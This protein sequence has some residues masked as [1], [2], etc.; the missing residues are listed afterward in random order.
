MKKQ[1]ALS[2]LFFLIA[3]SS[4][5]ATIISNSGLITYPDTGSAFPV[6]ATSQTV[7]SPGDSIRAAE[8]IDLAAL[9]F[10]TDDN[11]GAGWDT[12]ALEWV[13]QWFSPTSTGTPDA[14]FVV[15]YLWSQIT[16]DI[17][18][19]L[20]ELTFASDA[21]TP[22]ADG[23]WFVVS[24]FEN[25]FANQRAPSIAAVRVP[26]PATLLLLLIGFVAIGLVGRKKAVFSSKSAMIA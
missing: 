16:A 24:S 19:G 4:V 14:S 21:F 26:E 13:V 9:V 11:S 18:A 23:D 5:Q 7:F 8:T 1:I 12:A 15:P 6:P 25:D 10:A 3:C 17:T 2:L 22:T 20:T